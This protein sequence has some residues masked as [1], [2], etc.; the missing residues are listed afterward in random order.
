MPRIRASLIV[1][2]IVAL[3]AG[4]AKDT[5]QSPTSPSPAGSSS[6]TLDSFA[7]TWGS[8]T[9]PDQAPPSG[10]SGVEYTVAKKPDGKSADVTFKGTCAGISAVGTGTGTLG[11][12]T[13]N[14]SAQGTLTKGGTSCPFALDKST[15]AQ[16]G[17]GIRITYNGTVCGIFVSGS[18][19]VK[20]RQ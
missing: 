8:N 18:E 12:S 1:A 6:V 7:G 16:E 20:K 14:W 9:T 11:G 4:C 17:D 3:V 15:A 10:C 13:L 5:N 19:L 2:A